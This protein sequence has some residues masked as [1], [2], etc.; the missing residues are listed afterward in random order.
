MKIV[1]VISGLG[2]GG[3]E[4]ALLRL[5][6]TQRHS[7]LF[8]HEVISLGTR[9]VYAAVLEADAIPV[10]VLNIRGLVSLVIGFIRLILIL[11]EIKPNLIQTWMVHADFLGGLASFFVPGSVLIWGVRTT[12]YRVESFKTR[13]I[14]RVCACLSWV[15]PHK[16]VCAAYA[17]L[18]SCR[19]AGYDDGK[20]VVVYNGFDVPNLLTHV[21]AGK[22]LRKSLGLNEKLVVGCMGRYNPAK[23]Y[24]NFVKAAGILARRY[25]D[26]RFLLVG[27]G[28]DSNN[29]V[30]MTQIHSTGYG[31]RFLLLGERSDPAVCLDAMDIFVLSSCTEGFPNVLGEAMAMGTPCVTTDVGDAAVLLGDAGVV[32]PPKDSVALAE[33]VAKVLDLTLDKRLELGKK[34]MER[35]AR[36]F[37]IDCMASRFA[38]LYEESI[39]KA[40][41]GSL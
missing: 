15:L 35:V 19:E 31:D 27:K 25:P 37:S 7:G 24:E 2:R 28:V 33:G 18:L 38:A 29:E 41:N 10:H 14:R 26:C 20:L 12:D 13:G 23:D 30:L 22:N 40:G 1:H 32:V 8:H 9:G 6:E 36:H 5:I 11:R 34:G 21:G 16:V 3:A 17:S 39:V 4:N